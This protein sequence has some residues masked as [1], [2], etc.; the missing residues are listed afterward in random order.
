MSISYL[1]ILNGSP[2]ERQ[3]DLWAND[4]KVA[5]NLA[6]KGFTDYFKA[7]GGTYDIK[8]NAAGTNKVVLSELINLQPGHIYTLVIQ[9]AAEAPGLFF[10]TDTPRPPLK[11]RA[12]LRMINISPDTDFTVTLNGEDFISGLTYNEI[13]EFYELDPGNN[14]VRAYDGADKKLVLEVPKMALKDDKFYS[15]YIVGF[16]DGKPG[17]QIL[18]PQEG[19]A[20]LEM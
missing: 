3:L 20:F 13:T 12:A 14:H 7:E 19:M 18:V 1:R 10:V 15:C 6:Y 2:S 9:G 11:D 17:L 8:I 16:K 4:T 5:Q